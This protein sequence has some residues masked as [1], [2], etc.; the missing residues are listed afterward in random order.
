MR[1]PTPAETTPD[2]HLDFGWKLSGPRPKWWLKHV[3][4]PTTASS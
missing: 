4:L 1:A 2:T 3:S